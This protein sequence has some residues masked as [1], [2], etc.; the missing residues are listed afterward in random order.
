MTNPIF[1][2][3]SDLDMTLN[4]IL[5][6][7]LETVDELPTEG[8]VQGR[9]VYYGQGLAVYD[10]EKWILIDGTSVYTGGSHDIEGDGET[11]S[12]TF[13]HGLGKVPK[14]IDVVDADGYDVGATVRR[15]DE[16]VTVE[17]AVPLEVG[18]VLTVYFSG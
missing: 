15:D 11:A 5:N 9:I 18:T 13:E 14:H 2:V 3:S 10:G 6:G 12:F 8:L 17:V 16:T 1:R 7:V 4:Q